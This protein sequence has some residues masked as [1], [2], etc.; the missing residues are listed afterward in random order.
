MKPQMNTELLFKLLEMKRPNGTEYDV[1]DFILPNDSR[2]VHHT[3]GSELMAIQIDTCENP[4]T[5]FTCHLDTVEHERGIKQLTIADNMISVLN[6]GVLGAD[7]G[8]GIALLVHMIENNVP[9]RFMFF[10]MEEK[11][12]IGSKHI[13]KT[14][15]ELFTGIS[16]AIAFD[17]KGCSDVVVSQIGEEGCS[18]AFGIALSDALTTS[19]GYQFE[20]TVG[21]YTDTAEM[22]GLV[23]ECVNISCGYYNEHT[24]RESLDLTYLLKLSEAVLLVD[25]D[26]LPTVRNPVSRYNR[27]DWLSEGYSYDFGDYDDHEDNVNEI[28]DLM[29][30][31]NVSLSDLLE[32]IKDYKTFDVL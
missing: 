25:W 22:F 14:R 3:K 28:L 9:G 5:I 30:L 1:A 6:G 11:G 29:Q 21:V 27:I 10:A 23:P 2:I 31:N 4:T 20:P 12:G 7:D 32:A 18:N 15:P 8:A 26:S 19:T 13:V 24:S 17:R 16:R